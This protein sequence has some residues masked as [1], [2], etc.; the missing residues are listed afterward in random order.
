M[1]WL[2]ALLWFGCNQPPAA[3]PAPPRCAEGYSLFHLPEEALRVCCRH[4]ILTSC[5]LTVV[6]CQGDVLS[7]YCAHGAHCISGDG[8]ADLPQWIQE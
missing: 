3:T 2:V 5:G 4:A 7:Y 8:C 6:G 1:R